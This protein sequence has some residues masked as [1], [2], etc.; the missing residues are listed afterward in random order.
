MWYRFGIICKPAV[1]KL[2]NCNKYH[3]RASLRIGLFQC[4]YFCQQQYF[5]SYLFNCILLNDTSLLPF[6]FSFYY[7][8]KLNQV[9]TIKCSKQQLLFLSSIM[10]NS[11]LA[12]IGIFVWL[13]MQYQCGSIKIE[14]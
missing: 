2:V 10:A 12:V 8:W 13:Y 5:H 1:N 3:C 14:N 6:Y 4:R 11:V 9:C 7:E